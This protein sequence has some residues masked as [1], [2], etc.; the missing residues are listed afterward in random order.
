M[1]PCWLWGPDTE[2]LVEWKAGGYE[3]DLLPFSSSCQ[4]PYSK[5]SNGSFPASFA[6]P[7]MVCPLAV[8]ALVAVPISGEHT[9]GHSPEI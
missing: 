6:T 8:P 9:R 4:G 3:R 5:D 1:V 2:A 7:V